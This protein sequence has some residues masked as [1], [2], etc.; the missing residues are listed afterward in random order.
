M[1]TLKEIRAERRLV[2]YAVKGDKRSLERLITK[3]ID[4]SYSIAMIFLEDD[5]LSKLALEQTLG[6]VYTDIEDLYDPKG[7]RVWLY[8]I[9]KKEIESIRQKG[10]I[11]DTGQNLDLSFNESKINYYTLN[12]VLP[13]DMGESEH[14]LGL[15]RSLPDD[16]KEILVLIDFEGM[17]FTDT[18]ILTDRPLDE[19]RKTLYSAKKALI[20]GLAKYTVEKINLDQTKE[21]IHGIDQYGM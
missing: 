10:K 20:K 4:F 6:K 7:F 21:E 3:Y 12:K 18:A 15:V 2:K 13:A 11:V 17:T 14:L 5:K 19:V 8:D 16:Q 9:L 1:A